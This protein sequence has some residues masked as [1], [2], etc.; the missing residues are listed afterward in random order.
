MF[1]S[2]LF[3]LAIMSCVVFSIFGVYWALWLTGTPFN[4]MAFIGILAVSYTHLDVY[5]RQDFSRPEL[6]SLSPPL[7]IEVEG[8]DLDAIRDAGNKLAR[9]LRAN[10]HY[11]DVKSTVEQ[12]FPEIQIRFDQDLALIHI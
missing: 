6:F 12:G 7:E 10:G 9:M 11:A 2:L 1:E 4:I 8:Q 3:P 5:K